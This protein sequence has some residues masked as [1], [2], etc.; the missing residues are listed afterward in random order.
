MSLLKLN[1]RASEV[2]NRR[3]V[4]STPAVSPWRFIFFEYTGVIR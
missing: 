1:G 2:K 4:G 3:V